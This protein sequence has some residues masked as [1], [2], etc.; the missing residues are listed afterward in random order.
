MVQVCIIHAV[1]S[2]LL[3]F[4][5][6]YGA[7][8]SLAACQFSLTCHTF[9]YWLPYFFGMISRKRL[10][11][12]VG[13]HRDMTVVRRTLVPVSVSSR[14]VPGWQITDAATSVQLL[15]SLHGY[16]HLTPPF[17]SIMASF[18]DWTVVL[19][20]C[21]VVLQS[22]NVPK[23]LPAWLVAS[24]ASA[25]AAWHVVLA[26]D[27]RCTACETGFHYGTPD[28]ADNTCAALSLVV[29]G[30]WAAYVAIVLL[31]LKHTVPNSMRKKNA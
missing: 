5:V 19:L 24:A 30:L 29:H 8:L 16:R 2:I 20:C 6:D 12:V 31:V 4:G 27:P 26:F 9:S 11:H 10:V 17:S 15:P 7:I 14:L 1:A 13:M 22:P 25:W 21:S 23:A 3:V 28:W 18:A